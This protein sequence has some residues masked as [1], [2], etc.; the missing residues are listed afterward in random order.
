MKLARK[1]GPTSEGE[2]SPTSDVTICATAREHFF[3]AQSFFAKPVILLNALLHF[4]EA[5]SITVEPLKN[6]VDVGEHGFALLERDGFAATDIDRKILERHARGKTRVC[7]ASQDE[8]VIPFV[9]VFVDAF[10]LGKRH[11]LGRDVGFF[12]AVN[13]RRPTTM[14][15]PRPAE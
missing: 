10:G 1:L 2:A 11:C 9:R 15:R 6:F 14:V 8:L 5:G 7:P 13:A 4:V 12:H 3:L